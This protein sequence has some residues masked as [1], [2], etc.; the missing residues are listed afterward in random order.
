MSD[1]TLVWGT[2]VSQVGKSGQFPRIDINPR[3]GVYATSPLLDAGDR[4]E[5][6]VS[7]PIPNAPKLAAVAVAEPLDEPDA[8]AA[9][10]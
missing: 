8:K 10:R 3:D 6:I 7:S 4:P 1:M 2:T 5:E 9:V